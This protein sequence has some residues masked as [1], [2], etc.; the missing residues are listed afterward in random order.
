MRPSFHSIRWRIFAYYTGLIAVAIALLV[1]MYQISA[2]RQ[3]ERLTGLRLEARIMDLVPFLLPPRNPGREPPSRE[4]V[5]AQRRTPELRAMEAKMMADGIFVLVEN[6]DGRVVYESANGPADFRPPPPTNFGERYSSVVTGRFLVAQMYSPRGDRIFLGKP[7]AIVRRDSLGQLVRATGIG[8]AL[9][10]VVS[11]FGYV[12]IRRG[13]DPIDRISATAQSIAGGDLSGRIDVGSQRSE[14][15]EL[16]RVLNETFAR[17]QEALQRQVRFTADAS[18]ELRTPVAAILADCQF[19]LKRPREIE[20]YRETIEVCHESAQHMR[21]LIERLGVLAKFDAQDGPVER[22]EVDLADLARAAGGVIA[23]LADEQGVRVK[24][25]LVPAWISADRLRLGQAVINLLNNAVRYNRRDG[26]VWLR[27][28]HAG[29]RA[30]VEVQDAG[31]GIPAD[32]LDRVFERFFRVDDS[33]SDR[34]GG[35]GLGLAISKAIVEAHGG[36]L[37]VESE[38]NRGS[39]FRIEIP[40]AER[41][42]R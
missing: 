13:L 29:G 38:V 22:E 28:G 42:R 32:K 16:A 25:E 18:H 33:R 8:L 10:A 12:I 7:L 20:R 1:V 15:G 36:K 9:L 17:L 23:P 34:T 2:E 31:V 21:S 14:L 11:G 24:V 5:E 35:M 26:R 37:S 4:M 6:P 3:T 19:A 30:F 27:T 40:V 41:L 39:R